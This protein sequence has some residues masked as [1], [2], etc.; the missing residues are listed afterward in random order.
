LPPGFTLLQVEDVDVFGPSLSQEL[1]AAT[2]RLEFQ[3]AEGHPLPPPQ[4]W[5]AALD[6]LLAS[7]SWIWEDTD[8][9]GRPRQRD[10]R[11]YLQHVSQRSVGS[12]VELSYSAVIDPAGRSLRPDHVQHW[13]AQQ[14]ALPLELKGLSR[15]SLQLQTASDKGNQAC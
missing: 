9:K 11:P 8:K 3:S 4:A 7:G 1:S 2:W 14:L 10:L 5:Q 13:L 15:Q 12:A 6:A